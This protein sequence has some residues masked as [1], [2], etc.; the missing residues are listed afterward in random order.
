F[1]DAR[2]TSQK[3]SRCGHIRKA[4][5]QKSRFRCDHCGYTAHADIN[6]AMNVRD[7]YILSLAQQESGEQ[8][9]VNQPD[10]SRCQRVIEASPPCGRG[11][12]TKSNPVNRYLST[13]F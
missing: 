2:Y 6:A 9:A 4:N 11:E 3:C 12:L 13:Y 5:R 8:V 1:V 10:A 7:N